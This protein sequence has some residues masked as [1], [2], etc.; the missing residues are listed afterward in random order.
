MAP[1]RS[2][3]VPR[4]PKMKGANPYIHHEYPVPDLFDYSLTEGRDIFALA[5]QCCAGTIRGMETLFHVAR[6]EYDDPL[7]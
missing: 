2:G 5:M 3:K 7:M 1:L 4:Y 6:P